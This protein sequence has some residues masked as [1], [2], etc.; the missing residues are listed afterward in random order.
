MFA[1]PQRNVPPEPDILD[2]SQLL[3]ME[4]EPMPEISS[5]MRQQYMNQLMNPPKREDYAPSTGRKILGGLLAG[6]NGAVGGGGNPGGDLLNAK[7]NTARRDYGEKLEPLA[8]GAAIEKVDNKE[9]ME[10]YKARATNLR[11]KNTHMLNVM[12]AESAHRKRMEDINN[13]KEDNE[14]QAAIAKET[15]RHNGIMEKLRGDFQAFQK[16]RESN[17]NSRFNRTHEQR[18]RF[19][20]DKTTGKTESRI[21]VQEQQRI[22]TEAINEIKNDDRFSEFWDEKTESFK[23]QEDD[24]DTKN[25]L[26]AAILKAEERIA[27]RT[28]TD[29]SKAAAAADPFGYFLNDEDEDDEEIEE[30]E[31]DPFEQYRR[32]R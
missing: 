23:I 11:L 2:F 8:K 28:P 10:N 5:P 27:K 29:Y 20:E 26:G 32:R 6:I 14:R 16:T 18:E 13:L 12:K 17:R 30:E 9:T 7:F 22:R 3:D 21:P 1:P 31:E 15:E 24:E 25:A 4:E 19:H